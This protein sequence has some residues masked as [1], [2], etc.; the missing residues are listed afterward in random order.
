M[1]DRRSSKRELPGSSISGSNSSKVSFEKSNDNVGISRG[2]HGQDCLTR[3]SGV[4]RAMPSDAGKKAFTKKLRHLPFKVPSTENDVTS[5]GTKDGVGSSESSSTAASRPKQAPIILPREQFQILQDRIKTE[6]QNLKFLESNIECDTKGEG[7]AAAAVDDDEDDVDYDYEE[8]GSDIQ[9]LPKAERERLMLKQ[10]LKAKID[11]SK[12]LKT[13]VNTI[14]AL[15]SDADIITIDLTKESTPP[16]PPAEVTAKT[17]ESEYDS[18]SLELN[19]GAKIDWDENR[20]IEEMKH[21]P[22]VSLDIDESKLTSETSKKI[23]DIKNKIG[24]SLS[25]GLTNKEASANSEKSESKA[26]G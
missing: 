5:R 13:K 12:T 6:I 14:L 17:D 16:P 18:L 19:Y 24:R 4:V 26:G 15:E 9:F 20:K 25:I 23:T 3:K 2:N 1:S 21:S 7:A 8:L 10:S 22:V 11:E